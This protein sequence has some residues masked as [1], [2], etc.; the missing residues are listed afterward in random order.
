MKGKLGI[1]L[2]G[3]LLAT[4]AVAQFTGPAATAQPQTVAQVRAAS[5]GTQVALTGNIVNQ[6]RGDKFTFRDGTGEIRVEIKAPLWRERQVG[7]ADK[8]RL[9]GELDRAL[10]G[11]Y[12]RVMTLEPAQ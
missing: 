11:R 1:L 4:N 2:V 6:V 8:V 9:T 12:V 3:A 10:S 7:P 5:V